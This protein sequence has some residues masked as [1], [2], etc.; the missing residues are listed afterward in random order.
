MSVQPM[1][2]VIQ[3]FFGCITA[4]LSGASHCSYAI[5]NRVSNRS[6]CASADSAM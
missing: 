4:L 5:P 1:T 6:G 3:Q 2:G